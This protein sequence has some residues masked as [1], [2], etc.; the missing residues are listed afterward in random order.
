MGGQSSRTVERASIKP[1]PD[2][3]LGMLHDHSVIVAM[4]LCLSVILLS[5]SLS[6]NHIG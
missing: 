3:N 4:L 1:V 2:L 5:A 6:S